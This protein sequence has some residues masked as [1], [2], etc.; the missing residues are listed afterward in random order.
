MSIN[1]LIIHLEL[2]VLG[3]VLVVLLLSGLDRGS[4]STQETTGQSSQIQHEKKLA[5]ETKPIRTPL[6]T[7]VHVPARQR[8][9]WLG[10]L[11]GILERGQLRVLLPFSRTF[12]IQDNE[13]NLGL[14]TEI[15]TRYEQFL[16][17]QVVLGDNKMELV[18]LPTPEDRLLEDLLTGKG[19]IVAAHIPVQPDQE[20][21]VKTISPA[22]LEIQEILVTGPNSSQFKSIFNLSGQEITVRKNSSYAD[23]LQKL[24]NTLTSIGRKPVTIQ[25]APPFFQDEDLLEMTGAGIL[26]MTVIDDHIGEFWATVLHGIKLHK[27]IALRT[28][29]ERIWMIRADNLLLQESIRYFKENAYK[30]KDSHQRLTEY[31]RKKGKRLKNNL[32]L[33]ALERYQRILPLFEKYGKKYHFPPLL[34]AALAYQKSELDPSFIGNNGYVGLMGLDPS[35]ILQEGLEIDLKKIRKTEYNIHTAAR[36]LRFLADHYFSSPKLRELDRNMMTLAA[37]QASPEQVMTARKKTALAG[38][39]PDLWFNHT[40]EIFLA[41]GL[42][43]EKDITRSVRNIYKYFNAYEHLQ[44]GQY[45]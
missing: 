16:N 2:A 6:F 20:K 12:F 34:L 19:D 39:N 41:K 24:N 44:K 8:E 25:F 38:F 33:T 36:Y 31:Y 42:E 17:D 7:D 5:Q 37:Y 28:A 43:E 10:D 32:E 30:P 26:P 21:R 9:T 18:F 27:K 45:K 13:Q 23:S 40:A 15:L 29:K 22:A 3:F 14:S 4:Q 11:D 1:K 35:A